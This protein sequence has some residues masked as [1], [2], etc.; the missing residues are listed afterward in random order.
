MKMSSLTIRADT[1]VRDALEKAAKD[2][3]R[4]IS[5]MA[6]GILIE[7]LKEHGYLK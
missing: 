3:M 7:W 5:A 2:D 4:T 6:H 1:E